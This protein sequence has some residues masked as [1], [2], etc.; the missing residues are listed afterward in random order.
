MKENLQWSVPEQFKNQD[1]LKTYAG[2]SKEIKFI[3]FLGVDFSGNIVSE[4]KPVEHFIKNASDIFSKGISTKAFFSN[5]PEIENRDEAKINFVVD[6]TAKWFVEH[7]FDRLNSEKKPVGTVAIPVFCKHQEKFLCSRSVLKGT[8]QFIKKE[9]LLFFEN[10]PHLF[11]EK[12][13]VSEVKELEFTKKTT[14]ELQIDTLA[15][16]SERRLPEESCFEEVLELLAGYGFEANLRKGAK[17]EL[18]VSWDFKNLMAEADSKL[19]IKAL[20]KKAFERNGIEVNIEEKSAETDDEKKIYD[21]FNI[22]F[23]FKNG[24]TVNL[25]SSTDKVFSILNFESKEAAA[26]FIHSSNP[27]LANSAALIVILD[28][29]KHRKIENLKE[30]SESSLAKTASTFEPPFSVEQT[31]KFFNHTPLS[32]FVV[33]SFYL[34]MLKTW[35]SRLLQIEIP[36][37]IKELRTVVRY[38]EHENDFDHK[39]WESIESLRNLIGKDGLGNKSLISRLKESLSKQDYVKAGLTF[40]EIQ[41]VFAEFQEVAALYRDNIVSI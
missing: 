16:N 6:T 27:H 9:L 29:V 7:N 32:S 3:N 8:L 38:V 4:K 39:N 2:T 11:P 13:S 19:W 20:I 26:P 22:I 36:N 12:M 18:F 30:E 17:K 31:S 24:N 33:K 37:I 1:S 21:S 23:H 14:L 15:G 28:G 41:R 10:N 5:L 40:L 25:F 35:E 34:S